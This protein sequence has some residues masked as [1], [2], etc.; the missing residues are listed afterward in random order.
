MSNL[1]G[2]ANRLKSIEKNSGNQEWENLIREVLEIIRQHQIV[3][4]AFCQKHLWPLCELSHS[5]IRS[6]GRGQKTLEDFKDRW[7]M[8]PQEWYDRRAEWREESYVSAIAR[9]NKA[10]GDPYQEWELNYGESNLSSPLKGRQG[11]TNGNGKI[12]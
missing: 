3:N 5:E 12:Q 7:K 1:K 9:F 2:I 6:L 4:P 8:S 11:E 10:N